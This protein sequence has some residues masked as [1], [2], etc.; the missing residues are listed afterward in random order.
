[1]IGFKIKYVKSEIVAGDNVN[2]YYTGK[3]IDKIYYH[4]NTAYLVKNENNKLVPVLIHQLIEI[5]EESEK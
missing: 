2:T 4:S 1:M 5:L 3:I